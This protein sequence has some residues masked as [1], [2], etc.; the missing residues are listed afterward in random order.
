[1]ITKPTKNLAII[2]VGPKGLCE[3]R[4]KSSGKLLTVIMKKGNLQHNWY[5]WFKAPW[6]KQPDVL[7][8]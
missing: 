3:L 8:Q 4:K 6:G 5:G 7:E 1:M 2:D